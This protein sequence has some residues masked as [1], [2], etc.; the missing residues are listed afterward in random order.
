MSVRLS[1]PGACIVFVMLASVALFAAPCVRADAHPASVT[2]KILPP[3]DEKN[4]HPANDAT[5]SATREMAKP[6]SAGLQA[7]PS[8]PSRSLTP[9]AT[10]ADDSGPSFSWGGYFKAIG[11]LFIMLAVL[12]YI[13]WHLKRKGAI[14]GVGQGSL[15]KGA[16]RIEGSLSIGPRKGL[17]VVRFLNRRLL[18]GVTDR[19]ITLITELDDHEA[20]DIELRRPATEDSSSKEQRRNIDFGAVMR[21]V[22]KR[23]NTPEE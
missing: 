20:N 3:S 12:W 8:P 22:K 5:D 21:A 19:Q 10:E 18:L 7:E 6:E 16:L 9:L 15:P 1:A 14:P 23:K 17:F 4:R 11:T 13:V 2:A